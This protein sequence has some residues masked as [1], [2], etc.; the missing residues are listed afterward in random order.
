MKV[1]SE[2]EVTQSCP[3]LCH[4]VDSAQISAYKKLTQTSGPVL[5]GR[6]QKEERIQRW[7]LAK[8]DLKHNKLKK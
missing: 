7:S 6:N 5:E 4:P 3:I 2:S 1:K 8:E